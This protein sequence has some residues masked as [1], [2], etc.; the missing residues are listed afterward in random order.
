MNKEKVSIL[1]LDYLKSKRVIENVELLQKQ[2]TNFDVEII[3]ADNSCNLENRKKLESLEKFDNV[4]LIF[5]EENL[6]YTKAYNKA[7]KLAQGQYLF[8]VNPDILV[9][10]QDTLQKLVDY[11]DAHPD[12]AVIGPKQINDDG[13]MVF[14]AR[15][16]PKLYV[17]VARRTFLR[18]LFFF[19]QK[20]AYDEMRHLDLNQIQ[21]VDWL[22]SSFIVVRKDFWD[23]VKGLN[24]NYYMFMS[25]PELCHS[26]WKLGKKVIFYPEVKVYADGI[27][28]SEGGLF[29]FFKRWTMQQ[30]LIDSLKYRFKHF[31]QF[32]PRK[33]ENKTH[34]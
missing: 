9:K 28:C 29:D 32:N 12:V 31:F 24:E 30:H 18:K 14:T 22:Q 23:S 5:N 3:I 8:I 4:R 6:G 34:H 7:A 2:Q 10:D 17:Q 16:F 21:K 33:N 27:R 13:S 20:V 11:L 1:I 19:K 25:D 15:A 26:A